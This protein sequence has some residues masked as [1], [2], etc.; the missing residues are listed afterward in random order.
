MGEGGAVEGEREEPVGAAGRK[1]GE[2]AAYAWRG[3]SKVGKKSEP[4]VREEEGCGGGLWWERGQAAAAA[5]RKVG[6]GAV[7]GGRGGHI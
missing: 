5:G 2:V 3:G 4:L 6:E 1:E 7:Y